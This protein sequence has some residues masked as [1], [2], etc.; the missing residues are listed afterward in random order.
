MTEK[1]EKTK[2]SQSDRKQGHL[3]WSIMRTPT[4]R[5]MRVY[6]SGFA[7]KNLAGKPEV[8][9]WPILDDWAGAKSL[10]DAIMDDDRDALH[11]F[12]L[13]YPEHEFGFESLLKGHDRG[14]EIIE[15]RTIR[16]IMLK[17][18][19]RLD[20]DLVEKL[21][22]SIELHARIMRGSKEIAKEVIWPDGSA[23]L[24]EKAG[25]VPAELTMS[26]PE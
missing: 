25:M 22:E 12:T 23:S 2:L 6:P 8:M 20:I 16:S 18:E 10:I 7:K 14:G 9:W 19:H 26:M 11:E 17:R 4:R 24:A 5:A 21:D 13:K 15:R 1:K 3:G